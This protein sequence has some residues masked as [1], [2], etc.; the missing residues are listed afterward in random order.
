MTAFKRTFTD[1][2]PAKRE[3]L[4]YKE[5]ITPSMGRRGS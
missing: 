5:G 2:V 3:A 4:V 1:A